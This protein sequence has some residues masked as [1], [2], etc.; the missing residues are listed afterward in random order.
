MDDAQKQAL[1]IDGFPLV[2]VAADGHHYLD[3]RS[4]AR[5]MR[6][7]FLELEGI[8]ITRA[9]QASHVREFP[10]L[11]CFGIQRQAVREAL[12]GRR[13]FHGDEAHINGFRAAWPVADALLAVREGQRTGPATAAM[14]RRHGFYADARR[15]IERYRENAGH[16]DLA[17]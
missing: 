15:A 10:A 13:S 14:L 2:I 3:L 4:L 17:H 8:A 11:N 12:L 5:R 1:M 16:A 6:S 7:S 9:R